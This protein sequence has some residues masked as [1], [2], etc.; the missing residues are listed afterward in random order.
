[1]RVT[2]YKQFKNSKTY[3]FLHV[4]LT[5]HEKEVHFPTEKLLDKKHFINIFTSV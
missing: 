3:E 2:G 4:L 5:N 1:M